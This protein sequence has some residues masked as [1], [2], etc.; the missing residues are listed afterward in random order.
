MMGVNI[1]IKPFWI[2]GID[3]AVQNRLGFEAY[4]QYYILF[5]FVL[6]LSVLLDFGIGNYTTSNLAKN[7]NLLEKQFSALLTLKILFSLVYM[8]ATLVLA[9]ILNYDTNI[10]FLIFML[11]FNQVLSFF[12]RFTNV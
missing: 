3:R 5:N 4:G 11:S 9:A 1:L 7:P 12:Q 2:L 8:I 6:L 10:W